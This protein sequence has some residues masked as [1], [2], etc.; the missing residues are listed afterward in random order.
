[1]S[2][3]FISYSRV[4]RALA[5]RIVGGLRRL[6]VDVWWDEDMPGVD[7]QLELQRKIAELGAV[8]VLW[9]P[10]SME[11]KN[12]RDEARLGLANDKLVN[13]LAG[14]AEP[15]FPFDR[16]N[17]L[18]LGD[19]R[20][21]EA[22]PGWMRLVRTVEPMVGEAGALSAAQSQR[23]RAIADHRAAVTAA[24]GAFAAAQA[25]VRESAEAEDEAAHALRRGEKRLQTV[26]ETRAEAEVVRLAQAD[27]AALRARH[28]GADAAHETARRGLSDASRAL[29]AANTALRD[30]IDQTPPAMH[31]AASP[32]AGASP[33]RPA[34]PAQPAQPPGP[35]AL[36]DL[37]AAGAPMQEWVAYGERVAAGA[38]S[39]KAA[40]AAKRLAQKAAR[41]ERRRSRPVISVGG[42]IALSVVG[43][44]IWNQVNKPQRVAPPPA[45]V[46]AALAVTPSAWLDV[47]PVSRDGRSGLLVTGAAG[48]AALAASPLLGSAKAS[49]SR[50]MD[51]DLTSIRSLDSR[52]CDVVGALNERRRSP[53]TETPSLRLTTDEDRPGEVRA[54]IRPGEG[55]F[56]VLALRTNGDIEVVPA[57]ADRRPATAAKDLLAMALIS[58]HGPF[59]EAVIAGKASA[60]GPSWVKRFQTAA[61]AG[62]WRTALAWY[63]PETKY[64]DMGD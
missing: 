19:W 51:L 26:L 21:E 39:R 23:D 37:P 63:A 27:V 40:A 16:V 60:R 29:T 52:L 22:T 38:A 1:V 20:G 12:V 57:A 4:D 18:D 46:E 47:K 7:W 14:I 58:G 33:A 17:G 54:R 64:D 53:L 50:A 48:D 25:R 62:G 32:V 56:A 35:A 2:G 44:I 61:V 3:A 11:S 41:A 55:E 15:P 34:T 5:Y 10:A 30:L 24:E 36:A 45:A 59:E 9:S 31:H 13:V 8:V 43:W 49:V 6:G 42:I 28:E